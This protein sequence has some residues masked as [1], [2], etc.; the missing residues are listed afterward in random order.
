MI[1]TNRD[2]EEEALLKYLPN[3]SFCQERLDLGKVSKPGRP[4]SLCVFV[5][6]LLS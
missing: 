2:P 5:P 6:E 1:T 4:H 3:G